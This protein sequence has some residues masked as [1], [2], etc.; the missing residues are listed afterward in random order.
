MCVCSLFRIPNVMQITLQINVYLNI[1]L[2]KRL[3]ALLL[4]YIFSNGLH[5]LHI[6]FSW[7]ARVDGF[8]LALCQIPLVYEYMLRVLFLMC[9]LLPLYILSN[10]KSISCENEDEQCRSFIF[11]PH[12]LLFSR[13]YQTFKVTVM[14]PLWVTV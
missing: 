1:S 4:F 6:V 10:Q 12:I 5:S 13:Y 9:L 14:N 8:S 11:N 7:D 2:L 3:W